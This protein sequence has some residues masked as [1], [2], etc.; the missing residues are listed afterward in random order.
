M[1]EYFCRIITEDCTDRTAKQIVS[2]FGDRLGGIEFSPMQPY[3]KTSGQGEITCRFR[4]SHT[5]EEIQ[6]L[7]ADRWEADIA[8][9]SRSRIYCPGVVFLWFC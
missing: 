1:S 2:Y 8:D 9:P 3:W 6:H 4:S 5:L 7:F